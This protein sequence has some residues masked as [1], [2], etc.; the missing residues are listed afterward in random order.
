[1]RIRAARGDDF[2]RVAALLELA[3]RPPLARAVHDDAEAIYER[4]VHDPDSHHLVAE[5]DAGRVVGFCGLHFRRRLNRP[6]E[7]GWVPELFVLEASRSHGVGRALLDEAERRARDRGC[8]AFVLESGYRDAEG[9][10]LYRSRGM[11]DVGKQFR[12]DLTK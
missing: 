8:H 2:E 6:T 9:H 11:R 7:E 10:A 4:Q 12:R 3:G 5:D 1:V